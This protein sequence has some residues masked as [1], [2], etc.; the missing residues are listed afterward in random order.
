MK[1]SA[2]RLRRGWPKSKRPPLS[3]LRSSS[4]SVLVSIWS[5]IFSFLLL[6]LRFQVSSRERERT[7]ENQAAMAVVTMQREGLWRVKFVKSIMSGTRGKGL[8]LTRV[9]NENSRDSWRLSRTNL[10][11][12]VGLRLNQ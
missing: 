2:M 8:G 11:T 4:N 7:A 9:S 5:L 12:H 1:L 10:P 3:K 6:L